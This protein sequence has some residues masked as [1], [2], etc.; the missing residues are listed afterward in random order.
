MIIWI[1]S[2]QNNIVPN[3]KS[4]VYSFK[5]TKIWNVIVNIVFLLTAVVKIDD[6]AHHW[7]HVFIELNFRM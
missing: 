7:T 2:L 4:I 5:A 6:R 1:I 3:A